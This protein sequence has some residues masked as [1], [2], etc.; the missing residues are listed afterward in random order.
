MV[1]AMAMARGGEEIG[2]VERGWP[3]GLA[4]P[5]L[6][7]LG[8][9]SRPSHARTEHNP[10]HSTEVVAYRRT[11]NSLRD[12]SGTGRG[13]DGATHGPRETQEREKGRETYRNRLTY[14]QTGKQTYRQT[15]S[16][17]YVSHARG[18]ALCLGAGAPRI[19]RKWGRARFLGARRCRRKWC[20]NCCLQRL[21]K[22][23][24][25]GGTASAHA[26]KSVIQ[27]VLTAGPCAPL[28]PCCRRQGLQLKRGGSPAL[29][30]GPQLKRQDLLDKTGSGAPEYNE[31]KKTAH[32]NLGSGSIEDL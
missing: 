14:R 9:C 3:A 32:H 25:S 12:R 17:A 27:R 2:G 20:P 19:P 22:R 6:W 8:H 15:H 5:H 21:V 31:A 30:M 18:L 13:G 7:G 1:S 4:A 10:L 11:A 23:L 29:L 28:T 16:R 26:E 24:H